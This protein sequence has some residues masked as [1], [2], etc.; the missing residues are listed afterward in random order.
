MTSIGS[1][2]KMKS[3]IPVSIAGGSEGDVYHSRVVSIEVW[4]KFSTMSWK[5]KHTQLQMSWRRNQRDTCAYK[6]ILKFKK[7]FITIILFIL[8]I[9]LRDIHFI[10]KKGDLLKI[11]VLCLA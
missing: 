5:F 8:L 11:C 10:Y 6:S 1:K 9:L 7:I 2:E 3:G 4:E